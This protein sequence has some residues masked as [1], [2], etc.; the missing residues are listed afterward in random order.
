MRS[1]CTYNL[2]LNNTKKQHFFSNKC[3]IYYYFG[4]IQ[5]NYTFFFIILQFYKLGWFNLILKS[6]ERYNINEVRNV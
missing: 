6:Y 1:P 4:I 2:P 3:S 5:L